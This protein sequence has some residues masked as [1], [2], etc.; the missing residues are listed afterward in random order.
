MNKDLKNLSV[1]VKLL[2]KELCTCV[3]SKSTF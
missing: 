2:T 1:A 3:D